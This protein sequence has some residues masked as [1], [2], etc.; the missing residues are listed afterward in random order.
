[1]GFTLSTLI[2]WFKFDN[3]IVKPE[4]F[5]PLIIECTEENNEV[6]RQS[7]PFEELSTALQLLQ[8][9]DLEDLDKDNF[10]P[11]LYQHWDHRFKS[12]KQVF[13]GLD[14]I[15][16]IFES[17]L[18]NVHSENYIEDLEI[19]LDRVSF[20]RSSFGSFF[21]RDLSI[22]EDGYIT[23]KTVVLGLTKKL[24]RAV[25]KYGEVNNHPIIDITTK[26][27]FDRKLEIFSEEILHYVNKLIEHGT[28]TNGK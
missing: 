27:Y 28:I 3:T 23:F 18:E 2:S 17:Q 12:N 8:A 25:L 10:S 5:N 9:V 24:E 16:T 14:K 21:V 20:K 13:N 6:H 11:R 26:E 15:S 19:V 1:M 4:T 22:D 7:K